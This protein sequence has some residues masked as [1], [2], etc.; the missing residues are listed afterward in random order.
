MYVIVQSSQSR[1]KGSSAPSLRSLSV[2]EERMSSS[3]CLHH[4]LVTGRAFGHKISAPVT[5][6]GMYFS[7]TPLPSPLSLLSKKDMVGWC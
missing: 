6:Y 1:C 7:S 3:G 4:W 2:V 5:P